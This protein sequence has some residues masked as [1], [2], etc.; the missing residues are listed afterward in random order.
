MSQIPELVLP[1]VL[2]LERKTRPGLPQEGTRPLPFVFASILST[3]K[4]RSILLSLEKLGHVQQQYDSSM[5]SKQNQE[6]ILLLLLP[7]SFSWSATGRSPSLCLHRPSSPTHDCML[8]NFSMYELVV[9]R[10]DAHQI[11][12]SNERTQLR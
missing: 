5:D 2:L 12:F 1:V 7:P 11:H 4:E 10:I 9:M 8:D 3:H 6:S